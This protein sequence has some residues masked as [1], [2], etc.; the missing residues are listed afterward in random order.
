MYGVVIFCRTHGKYSLIPVKLRSRDSLGY[1]NDIGWFT[2][3]LNLLTGLKTLVR[4]KE[5][6]ARK[7]PKA[8]ARCNVYWLMG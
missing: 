2:A 5:R 3:L 1:C 8:F 7:D 4:D 6:F